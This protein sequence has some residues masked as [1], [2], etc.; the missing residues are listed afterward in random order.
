VKILIGRSASIAVLLLLLGAA[1]LAVSCRRGSAIEWGAT[2]AVTLPAVVLG[3]GRPV[4]AALK[5]TLGKDVEL[6][7][8]A[9]SKF[10]LST[11]ADGGYH[12][13]TAVSG[14]LTHLSIPVQAF[15]DVTA[16]NFLASLYYCSTAGDK[17]CYF[18]KFSFDQPLQWREDAQI[19]NVIELEAGF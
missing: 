5:I 4:E 13:E 9:P 2:T 16:V 8:G 6:T 19:S 18:R 14:A 15:Q 3:T 11:R 10:E 17:L 12:L 1:I 7:P